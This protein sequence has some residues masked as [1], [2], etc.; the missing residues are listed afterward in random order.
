WRFRPL[1]RQ[2]IRRTIKLWKSEEVSYP[3]KIQEENSLLTIAKLTNLELEVILN[4]NN[5]TTIKQLKPGLTIEMPCF[6]AFY[7]SEER[8]SLEVIAKRFCYNSVEEL[9]TANQI[10]KPYKIYPDQLVYLPGWFLFKIKST[11][12]FENLDKQFNMPKGWVRPLLRTLHDDPSLTYE[13]EIIA[14]PTADFIQ[15]HK[16]KSRFDDK[17]L[18]K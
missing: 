14:S 1:P 15:A 6:K 18:K 8:D 4:E 10:S 12:L 9:A 16:L 3:Y 17:S 13:R 11:I 2:K 5:L 7:H